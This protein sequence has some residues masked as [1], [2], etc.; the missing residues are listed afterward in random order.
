M[1]PAI[2]YADDYIGETAP[3]Q[4]VGQKYWCKIAKYYYDS[5]DDEHKFILT[6]GTFDDNDN[7]EYQACIQAWGF[8]EAAPFLIGCGLENGSPA[9][10]FKGAIDE[11]IVYA[12]TIDGSWQDISGG[13][14]CNT[15]E[16]IAKLYNY[17]TGT[18]LKFDTK[19]NRYSGGELTVDV[20]RSLISSG[21]IT[22]DVER[23]IT[24]AGGN[25]EPNINEPVVTPSGK[26]YLLVRYKGQNWY[27]PMLTP[28]AAGLDIT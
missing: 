28:E 22:A 14:N 17:F 4:N 23:I 8:H 26:K 24:N 7:Y 3:Q 18:T 5:D 2:N 6:L 13:I 12:P 16:G 19:I 10:F 21:E 27:V 11:F 25:T 15:P 1:I 20:V 9:R